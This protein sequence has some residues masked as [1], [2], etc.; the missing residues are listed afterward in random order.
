MK[1][2]STMPVLEE[3]H[4]LE[5]GAPPAA[6]YAV[7]GSADDAFAS[8][9][10]NAGSV[11]CARNL[12]GW[13]PYGDS[14][15]STARPDEVRRRHHGSDCRA[16]TRARSNP[17]R[18]YDSSGCS[19]PFAQARVTPKASRRTSTKAVKSAGAIYRGSTQEDEADYDEGPVQHGFA[20]QPDLWLSTHL[21]ERTP[22]VLPLL[23]P[24]RVDP[25]LVGRS[26]P[27]FSS[28][29]VSLTNCRGGTMPL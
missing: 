5:K 10:R 16:P 14:S 24:A 28:A 26:N 15:Q 4:G 17:G 12:C 1:A 23:P 25:N 8:G 3:C 27:C 22:R 7:D 29:S 2:S 18:S 6:R 13:V 11:D 20:D 19:D 9:A 21:R